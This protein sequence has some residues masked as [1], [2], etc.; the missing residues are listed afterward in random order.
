ME[1]QPQNPE[2]RYTEFRYSPKNFTHA[3]KQL[4]GFIN[5]YPIFFKFSL[6]FSCKHKVHVCIFTFSKQFFNE[7]LDFCNRS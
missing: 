7:S 6:H 5:T 4:L 1:S 2:F 3:N